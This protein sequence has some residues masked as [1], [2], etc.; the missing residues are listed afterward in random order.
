MRGFLDGCRLGEELFDEAGDLVLE[1]L[2]GWWVGGTGESGVDLANASVPAEDEGGWPAVEMV[3]LRDFFGELI[4]RSGYEHGIGNAVT[5]DEGAEPGGVLELVFFFEAEVHDL[6]TLAVKLLVKAFEEG[7]FIVAVGAPGAADGDDHDLI[8]ELGV[9]AGDLFA[10]EIGEAEGEGR[11]GI[12]DAGLLGGLGGRGEIFFAGVGGTACDEV[13]R[14]GLLGVGGEEIGD[15]K[16]SIRLGHDGVESGTGGGEVADVVLMSIPGAVEGA[17]VTVDAL[18]DG[19]DGGGGSSLGGG[20]DAE[21]P[22]G[23]ALVAG[24]GD[25]PVAM[26]VRTG[27]GGGGAGSTMKRDGNS[28]RSVGTGGGGAE[29]SRELVSGKRSF[30][31]A[32]EVVEVEEKLAV[33]QGGRGG[34]GAF[35]AIEKSGVKIGSGAGDLETEGNFVAANGSGSFPRAAN[36]RG[37]GSKGEA[38]GGGQKDATEQEGGSRELPGKDFHGRA[39]FFWFLDG[40][41]AGG[42]T[43]KTKVRNAPLRWPA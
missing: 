43:S 29:G 10:G 14:L 20:F 18:D 28:R 41:D 38:G 1:R 5:L 6:E 34:C 17:G 21:L 39:R 16:S 24:D 7:S 32:G 35:G 11:G 3:G 22:G 40:G 2:V 9:G 31:G 26:D 23:F 8:A 13:A 25:L 42:C 33:L 15:K 12:F 4:G 19:A 30:E 27:G 37:G 36:G